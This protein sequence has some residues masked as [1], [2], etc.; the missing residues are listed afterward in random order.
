[1]A[2]HGPLAEMAQ[3]LLALLQLALQGL[4]RLLLM[5]ELRPVLFWI[6]LSLEVTLAQLDR[7]ALLGMQDLLQQ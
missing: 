2:Q 6:L 1:M 4:M 3:L 7:L 5:L